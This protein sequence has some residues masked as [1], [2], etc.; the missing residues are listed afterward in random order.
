MNRRLDDSSPDASQ[1]RTTT[2]QTA[3][4]GKTVARKRSWFRFLFQFSLR[5]L[6]IATTLVAVACWWYLQPE[7]KD[8]PLGS[9]ELRLRRQVRTIAL[10]ESEEQGIALANTEDKVWLISD[11]NYRIVDLHDQL[12]VDGRMVLNRRNGWW[13]T[14]HTSG[15]KAVEGKLV[16]GERT[17][18][19][20][21]WYASG[22]LASEVTY[23]PLSQ[24]EPDRLGWQPQAWP[25]SIR[26][27]SARAWHPNGKLKLEGQ[28][29]SD[30]RDGR[31]SYFDQQGQLLE[32]GS[33][34]ADRRD[35]KWTVRDRETGQSIEVAYVAGRTKAEH[36]RLMAKLSADVR[37]SDRRLQLNAIKRL[38]ELGLVGAEVLRK[39]FVDGDEITRSLTL[40]SL[41]R[42][43]QV[44]GELAALI[45]PL[46][47][48][49]N[50][51]LARRAKL[52]TVIALHEQ[53]QTDH[54]LVEQLL[55]AN[56]AS[57][58][59]Q[60]RIEVLQSLCQLDLKQRPE[61]FEQLVAAIAE[62]ASGPLG[63]AALGNGLAEEEAW[64][65]AILN[66]DPILSVKGELAPLL[67]RAF[68]S[69]DRFVR[70]T[71]ILTVERVVERG[72]PDRE[73]PSQSPFGMAASWDV[74]SELRPLL[75]Q[76]KSDPEEVVRLRTDDV[77]KAQ[78]Y[79]YGSC[80]FRGGSLGGVAPST[81]RN[82]G[83]GFF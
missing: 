40:R 83:G 41:L 10:S 31:W 16:R 60:S 8:E 51:A 42:M 70:A 56:D 14:Y 75:E 77:G 12:L 79:S 48:H 32:R 21:T 25:G 6:L 52:A 50:P 23:R 78:F 2:G 68:A 1:G 76:A 36:D 66:V 82:L 64:R 57:T 24:V 55:K 67:E 34:V 73:T 15:R 63:P 44:D 59:A 35:G 30:K 46:T 18:R 28:Y 26:E 22:V 27:G 72:P 19:W 37:S 45:Q 39:A 43:D 7:T 11:G 54:R 17:G 38:E 53:G 29:A 13:T 3:A 61:I 65:V 5:S 20:R 58:P 47:N 69:P 4:I 81:G 49:S 33:Y 71:V 62:P 80:C 74:P 9:G